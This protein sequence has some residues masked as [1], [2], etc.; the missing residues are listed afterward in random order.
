MCELVDI[1]QQVNKVNQ[2]RVVFQV[3][4]TNT[5]R[6]TRWKKLYWTRAE[7]AEGLVD[8]QFAQLLLSK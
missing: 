1:E 4:V 3:F 2:T 5:T 6:K 8:K 7:V